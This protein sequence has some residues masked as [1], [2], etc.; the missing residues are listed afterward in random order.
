MT[1]ALNDALSEL[2]REYLFD[3]PG[4]L[5]ELRKDVAAYRAGEADAVTSLLRRFHRLAGLGRL[6]RIPRDQRAGAGG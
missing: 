4:R 3:A 5:A 1:D 6:L 2:R